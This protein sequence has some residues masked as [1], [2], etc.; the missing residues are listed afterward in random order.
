MLSRIS[1]DTLSSVKY[2]K[3]QHWEHM[4]ELIPNS[5]FRYLLIN[6]YGFLQQI[7]LW[8]PFVVIGM[9]ATTLSAALGN[10]IGASRV[11]E[12]LARD[13]LFCK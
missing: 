1:D 4:S 12:A 8:S 13:E 2:S 6:D 9:F 3:R 5:Y 7:N 11:L 10:L